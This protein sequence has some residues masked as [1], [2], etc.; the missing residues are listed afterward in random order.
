[1]KL[2]R[3]LDAI[4]GGETQ[5]DQPRSKRRKRGSSMATPSDSVDMEEGSSEG[6]IAGLAERKTIAEQGMKIWKAVRNA[7]GKE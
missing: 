3:E 7:K 1:M 6:D 2:K 5:G 4:D